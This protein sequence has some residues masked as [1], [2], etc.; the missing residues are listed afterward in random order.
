MKTKKMMLAALAAGGQGIGYSPIQ[1][2][3]F[4]FLIDREASDL[5]NGPFFK[6]EAFFYGP[7]DR[8]VY[9]KMDS[10]VKDGFAEY[11]PNG[12]YCSS[13]FLT[14]I[15]YHKGKVALAQFPEKITSFMERSA[16][17]VTTL[18][19]QQMLS[20]IFHKYPEMRD[21]NRSD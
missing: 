11:K 13:Y 1:V 18:S 8:A 20:Q 14:D 3:K 15:G 17:W 4:F 9:A 19:F 5:M 2:Q 6:F 16:K 12:K 21:V 7:S 10:L